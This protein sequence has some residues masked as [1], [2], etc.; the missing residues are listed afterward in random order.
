MAMLVV[1][2][3]SAGLF[4]VPLDAFVQ[5]QAPEARRGEILACVNFLG[6]CGA[7]AASCLLLFLMQ[8]LHL[9]SE[10]CFL[11]LGI[12]TGV[13]AVATI[14]VLPDFLV[15]FIGVVVTK[16]IYRITAVG[17]ENIP[18]RGPALL[19]PN[20]V[21]WAD[22]LFLTATLQRR[23]R[24]LMDREIYAN[25]WFGFIFRL[26]RVIPISDQDGPRE[27][28]R[29][30][31]QAR[32]A[33][34]DGYLVCI[35]ADGAVTRNGNMQA[36]KPGLEK[37]AGETGTPIIPVFIGDA[38]GSIFS[39][40]YGRLLSGW[41]P[42][43]PYPV[44]VIYG[45]AMDSHSTTDQVRRAVQE[46]STRAFDLEPGAR[47]HNLARLF[48]R[49]A[50]KRWL[51][52]AVSDTN[53]KALTFGQTLVGAIALGNALRTKVEDQQNVGIL[54]PSS[55]GGVL[56]NLAMAL[57]GKVAVNINFTAS[58]QAVSSALKQCEIR[59]VISSREFLEK[60][61]GLEAP[62]G[63]LMIEDLLSAIGT[64]TKLA[65]F[66]KGALAPIAAFPGCRAGSETLATVIFSSGSTAEPKGVMLS[67]RNILS[68]I[69][70]FRRVIRL[71]YADR[72]CGI[73]PFFHSFGY[74]VTLWCP[75]VAGLQA[76]YHP[77]P[78][79][80]GTIAEMVRT[81]R[82]TIL[83]STPTFLLAYI[84]RALKEDFAS[85]R[86][87]IT[88]A[89]KLKPRVADA[90][91]ER[92]GLRPM[93]GYGATE[94]SPVAAVSIPD[95]EIDGLK[96]VGMKSGSVGHPIPGVAMKVVDA[97]TGEVLPPDREGLLM[98]KG[99]NVMMGY[100]NNPA[101]TAD[102]LSDGW[103]NTGD[104]AKIDRDGFV[105]LL[106]R[107][108][109][110]S[111]IG[112]EMVPHIAIEE[113]YQQALKTMNQV[114]FVTA[115][116]DEKKGEQ[117]IVFYTDE[118]GSVDALHQIISE[119]DLPNL[120]KPKKDNY[121]RLESVPTLGSGKLDLKRMKDLA[122]VFVETRPGKLRQVLDKILDKF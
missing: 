48:V 103:Y 33:L 20:H 23:I 9:R 1:G 114:V 79:D 26:M 69:Q 84:R 111:K 97:G 78:L 88:G 67:H 96:Q 4:V 64:G 120:W 83:L 57:L 45:A 10:Q 36:F 63:T 112:G 77:N 39:H 35:F 30:I 15:R 54:L 60:L 102:V 76:H 86:A 100:L 72:M 81:R 75:L 50:R 98:V 43:I 73:L 34:K 13:L 32:E 99:A 53:G 38:W 2:G 59:T 117:I 52:P 17:L 31:L 108:S 66:L 116:P 104:L 89:E 122:K 47:K 29:S 110:Y 16:C 62:P 7:A 85:L 87:V 11:V 41:P 109:R 19:V 68:N 121:V 21:T 46:L 119:S 113:K 6:F 27:M 70:S 118:A 24:F 25:R 80:G 28:V 95:V 90:F 107:M 5:F 115:A 55:V 106:D 14:W 8:V 71:S 56:A 93:E 40:Y 74:T 101:K 82:L 18:V 105:F 12:L 37:M 51:A 61:E 49:T 3:V 42:R 94:L 65:A 58:A 22:A 91:E 92:F 44:T